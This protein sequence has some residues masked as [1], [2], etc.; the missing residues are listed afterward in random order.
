MRVNR[1]YPSGLS[2]LWFQKLSKIVIILLVIFIPIFKCKFGNMVSIY[3]TLK[4]W[5]INRVSIKKSINFT[6]ILFFVKFLWYLQSVNLPSQNLWTF[7]KAETHGGC[8]ILKL[9][10]LNSVLQMFPSNRQ[11][12][13]KKGFWIS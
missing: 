5:L 7:S 12:K 11:S 13:F 3:T 1:K 4:M 8:K 6:T 10:P 9:I 2:H